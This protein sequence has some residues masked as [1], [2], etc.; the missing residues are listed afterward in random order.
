MIRLAYDILQ[1]VAVSINFT[2]LRVEVNFTHR[3][4]IVDVINWM[5]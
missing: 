1:R 2:G 4:L 3:G 5:G